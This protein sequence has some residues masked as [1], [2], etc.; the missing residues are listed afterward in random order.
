MV[1]DLRRFEGR[2]QAYL[3]HLDAEGHAQTLGTGGVGFMPLVFEAQGWPMA[4]RTVTT[5]AVTV[6]AVVLGLVFVWDPT[7]DGLD[8]LAWLQAHY[9]FAALLAAVSFSCAVAA[10]PLYRPTPRNATHRMRRMLAQ[11]RLSC[12]GAGNLVL[13][14]ALARGAVP[15]SSTTARASSPSSPSSSTAAAAAAA[16][17]SLDPANAYSAPPDMRRSH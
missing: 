13:P 1:A 15:A 7:G 12:D 14:P 5:V 17:A 3:R 2:F 10:Q 8:L 16:A 11:F 9:V 4:A 6:W